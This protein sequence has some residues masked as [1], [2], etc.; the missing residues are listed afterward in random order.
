M[1]VRLHENK[2][3]HRIDGEAASELRS[4]IESGN[5]ELVKA[6]AI[7]ILERCRS[8]FDPEEQDYIMYDIDDLIDAFNG[9]PIDG[10][11]AE[12]FMDDRLEE[13]YSFCDGNNILID[14]D[15]AAADEAEPKEGE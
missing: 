1:R 9:E 8:F 11:D 15:G 6:N 5:L 14:Y 13:L 10:E 7:V 4:A 2:W 12:E 3:L